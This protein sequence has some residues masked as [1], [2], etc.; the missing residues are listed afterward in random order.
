[1]NWFKFNY[2]APEKK[3]YGHAS[4]CNTNIH[5]VLPR[6][7]YLC[8]FKHWCAQYT[9]LLP[10]ALHSTFDY[11]TYTFICLYSKRIGECRT[12][13]AGGGAVSWP[14]TKNGGGANRPVCKYFQIKISV[15]KELSVL[16]SSVLR[17]VW[18]GADICICS[19]CKNVSLWGRGD[20]GIICQ[21]NYN[22][23]LIT[24]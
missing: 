20:S 15:H 22:C 10:T 5:P 17:I 2:S 16:L 4:E 13:T 19:W 18:R 23:I 14:H 9:I 24:S 8:P 6:Y 1:M 12:W 11:I 7:S 21:L 3:K